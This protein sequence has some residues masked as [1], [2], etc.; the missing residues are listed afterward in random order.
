MYRFMIP[1]AKVRSN[2]PTANYFDTGAG[3]EGFDFYKVA[4][5]KALRGII[6]YPCQGGEML[7]VGA[8]YPSAVDAHPADNLDDWQNPS[9]VNAVLETYRDFAPQLLELVTIAEGVK[10]WTL[11]N[12][13]PPR[14]F[15]KDRLVLVGDAAHP[16]HPREF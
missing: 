5:S 10:H 6:V 15:T 8:M 2:P 11:A 3:I 7:N 9:S 14:T 12:R 16:M 13:D 1:S 4:E